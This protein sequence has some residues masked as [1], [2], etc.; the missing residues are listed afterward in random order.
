MKYFTMICMTVILLT[1]GC[2][3]SI[4]GVGSCEG[5][6]L[7]TVQGSEFPPYSGEHYLWIAWQSGWGNRLYLSV[8]DDRFSW[9]GQLLCA[10]VQFVVTFPEEYRLA[11]DGRV[12]ANG[13]ITGTVS[14][15]P[16]TSESTLGE[17][18]APFS[19]AL[20]PVSGRGEGAFA[21]RGTRFTWTALF[22]DADEKIPSPH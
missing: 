15:N 6:W 2:T 13:A 19:G 22:L 18:S 11:I 12:L 3:H 10:D 20:N 16:E 21:I 14:W 17:G 9:Q 4:T 5:T 1:C 7:V 8:A